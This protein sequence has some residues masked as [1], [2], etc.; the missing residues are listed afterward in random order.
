MNIDLIKKVAILFLLIFSAINLNAQIKGSSS[1]DM[2]EM[3]KSDALE[4]LNSDQ[5]SKNTIPFGDI[6]NP[7]YYYLGPGD[8]L[9]IQNLS[10]IS[11]KEIVA[12]SPE[13]SIIIPRIGLID[14]SNKTLSEAKI[15]I[16]EKIKANIKDALVYVSL[17]KPRNVIVELSG[18]VD[19]PGTYTY[20]ASFRVSTLLKYVQ[21]Q[22]NSGMMPI[23]QSN[24]LYQK[25]ERN[26]QLQVLFSDGNLPLFSDY[27]SRNTIVLHNDGTS[28]IVDFELATATNNIQY[29]PH[30]REGDRIHVPFSE[31]D[32]PI[33]TIAGSVNR[34]Y[35]TAYKSGDKASL[36]LKFGISLKPDADLENVRLILPESNRSMSLKIDEK[37]SLLSEDFELEPGS[38]IIIG[39]KQGSKTNENGV[40]SVVGNVSKPGIYPIKNFITSVKDIIG[41]AGGFTDEAYLPLAY[42]IRRD[43]DFESPNSIQ[44]QIMERFQYSNLTQYDTTRYQIDMRLKQ[45]RVSCDFVALFKNN[46]EKANA[47]LKDGDIIKIPSNPRTVFVYGQVKNP[48]YI[49]F[50]ENKN[51]NYYI[52]KAGGYTENAEDDNARIIRGNNKTWIV[53]DDKVYVYAGDEV[54]VPAPPAI[55]LE[56]KSQTYMFYA[57]IGSLLLAIAQNIYWWT[58]P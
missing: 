42:I 39:K 38:I 13:N 50:E 14:L 25:F 16:V 28:S 54:Y 43:D 6:V 3:L 9:V 57:S 24:A 2:E 26:K 12:V 49:K 10:T 40:V 44:H 19:I 48:G 11:Q 7:D 20:P 36:L 46:D 41:D 21:Q 37:M 56:V 23:H 53:G 5:I 47:Y 27:S 30:I 15:L 18:N 58:R 35:V 4:Q 32:F 31:K 1:Y 45:P 8:I 51:M 17:Q 52:Q 29:D 33:I 55:P 22:K 34:P